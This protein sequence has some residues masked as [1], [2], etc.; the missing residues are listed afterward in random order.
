MSRNPVSPRPAGRRPHLRA[1]GL[2]KVFGGVTAV[3]DLSLEVQPGEI[4]GLVGPDGA[5]KTTTL[6]LLAGVLSPTRGRA[7]IDGRDVHRQP[8]AIRAELGYMAQRFS[9]YGDL[10]VRENLDF[11]AAVFG[12]LGP[13]LP[14]RRR[15]LLDFAR[16]TAFQDRRAAHLSG[17]MKKKLA[18]AATL[19]HRP[20]L[21]LLDEPTTGVDPISR[22]EFWAILA[23]L[24]L[25][26]VT[27]VVATPYLDEAE[28]CTRVVLL[29][30][31]RIL[32]CDS[33]AAIRDLLPGE[34]WELRVRPQ[35]EARSRLEGAPGVVE[36][37]TY[38]DR[39][40][41]FLEE[42]IDPQALAR[43]RL[44]G[45]ELLGI[46]RARP[47]LEEAFVSLIRKAEAGVEGPAR[48]GP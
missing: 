14:E 4:F 23:E 34:V 20:R 38:G 5:G 13:S 26:G 30:R 1:E 42:G 46:R 44:A 43:S 48:E 36:V 19:I 22:R 25:Q 12:V 21:V 29:H 18:L 45:L 15:R 17:G 8:E 33:P 2:T 11:F 6:R 32:V 16:L 7:T 28:R 40:H 31:G 41:L 3:Q 39:L 47:R 27:L 24:H 10:S 9:L 35:R 37:Q